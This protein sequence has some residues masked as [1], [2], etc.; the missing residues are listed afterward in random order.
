MKRSA[1]RTRPS[2]SP[3]S[4][5]AR[6][7]S[8]PPL[9]SSCCRRRLC[10]RLQRCAWSRWHA[11]RHHP[12]RCG[13]WVA[14]L[15]PRRSSILQPRPHRM[16]LRQLLRLRP[17]RL[18]PLLLPGTR[19]RC[20]QGTTGG[21]LLRLPTC[22]GLLWRLR[23]RPGHSQPHSTRMR[24]TRPH[25]S[26]T[27]RCPNTTRVTW[28]GM[29]TS[30]RHRTTHLR[31]RTM[32]LR[33]RTGKPRH[34]GRERRESREDEEE[35]ESGGPGCPP[36][37]RAEEAAA[38]APGLPTA[39]P[40]RHSC[41]GACDPAAPSGAPRPP[42]LPAG[43]PRGWRG[44]ASCGCRGW[45]GGCGACGLRFTRTRE[46]GA[47]LPPPLPRLL[48]AHRRWRALAAERALPR[49][50]PRRERG[51]GARSS[52]WA[53]A[54]HQPGSRRRRLVRNATHRTTGAQRPT[55]TGPSRVW[56]VRVLPPA[57]VRSL[58]GCQRMAGS[59]C[60]SPRHRSLRSLATC[61]GVK[62]RRVTPLLLLLGGLRCAP[63]PRAR[64][65]RRRL[66][67]APPPW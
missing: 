55:A 28:G 20:A 35:V 54:A 4:S 31:C 41:C 18:L 33:C 5:S 13:P 43:A 50:T 47:A 22:G 39:P 62:S 36:L 19:P 1:Q 67:C 17:M 64:A 7:T 65:C 10:W 3:P 21:T 15:C 11:P 32:R 61:P 37:S 26:S 59:C 2:H 12:C 30:R 34:A 8:R 53:A 9:P 56:V 57:V 48:W 52:G 6:R 44:R 29:R 38:A 66:C 40:C 16:L 25:S 42:P 23:S 27:P 51:A 60:V 49:V 46:A 58:G 14:P 63:T 24:A 45:R